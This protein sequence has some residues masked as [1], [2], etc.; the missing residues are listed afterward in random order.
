[1][2]PQSMSYPCFPW[3]WY[4]SEAFVTGLGPQRFAAPLPCCGCFCAAQ[5]R[6]V[7]GAR[8]S[9]WVWKPKLG[10]GLEHCCFPYIGNNH[11]NELTVFI[12]VGIPPTRK[13]YPPTS[14]SMPWWN[15]KNAWYTW[16]YTGSF[17][18]ETHDVQHNCLAFGMD[19]CYQ[20][21]LVRKHLLVSS[22][23]ESVTGSRN[24]LVA[25]KRQRE[26]FLHN[27]VIAVHYIHIYIYILI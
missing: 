15:R 10:G 8:D 25:K 23:E 24:W 6:W 5:P 18:W 11:P 1:M 12:W 26:R 17:S 4:A 2:H 9:P 22:P 14:I 19:I 13:I 16:W 7:M 3:A 20:Q 21:S 27:I